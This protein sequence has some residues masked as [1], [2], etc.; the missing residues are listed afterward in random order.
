MTRLFLFTLSVISIL[1]ACST[2]KPVEEKAAS[3]MSM[4]F[5]TDLV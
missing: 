5:M 1:F 3:A 4:D 2:P